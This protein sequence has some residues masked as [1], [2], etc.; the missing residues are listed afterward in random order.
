[1][2]GIGKHKEIFMN[3]ILLSLLF[4]FQAHAIETGPANSVLRVPSG[5]GRALMGA[6]NL[7]SSAAVTG[8]L[9]P[10][11][12]GTGQNFSSSTGV[13]SAASGTVSAGT[14]SIA[15]GCTGQTS[16]LAAFNALSPMTT[17]GDLIYGGASGAGTRLANGTVGQVLVSAGTTLAPVWTT[18][19][20]PTQFAQQSAVTG[21]N[22]A[23]ELFVAST[24]TTPPT[25]GATY[26]NNS[27]TF[28]VLQ[29]NNMGSFY[30][31]WTTHPGAFTISGATLTKA[32]GTGDASISFI[33]YSTSGFLQA[34]PQSQQIYLYTTPTGAKALRI[35]LIG[36]GAA[37][38]GATSP[39]SASSA[40]GGGG[41]GGA[42]V[43]MIQSPAASYYYTVGLKG[44]VGTA[45]NNPGCAGGP[46]E[47]DITNTFTATGGQGGTGSGS[48]AAAAIGGAGGFGGGAN[49]GDYTCTGGAGGTG[50]ILSAALSLGGAGGVA[51]LMSGTTGQTSTI[52]GGGLAGQAIGAGGGGGQQLSTSASRAGG[53]AADGAVIVEAFSQ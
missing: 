26:T 1:V 9:L 15:N 21:T 2:S 20:A 48:A 46:T 4:A 32:T 53:S 42:S 3:K 5:G 6:V 30:E 49:G 38:G 27:N 44:S 7:G 51:C 29:T 16:A 14:C 34:T 45:G 52:S 19:T 35:T 10:A 23:G 47:W 22:L 31:I 17:G 12:G 36:G 37:G 43:K 28:T 13:L 39:G 8:Q 25:A 11:N 40:G 18:L 41:G 33:N 50:L 24:L